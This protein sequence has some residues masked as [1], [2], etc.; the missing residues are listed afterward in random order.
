[1]ALQNASDN[2][3]VKEPIAEQTVLLYH[4]FS[5]AGLFEKTSIP[6]TLWTSKTGPIKQWYKFKNLP[7]KFLNLYHCLKRRK[8][9]VGQPKT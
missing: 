8:S 1:M 4:A 6:I 3:V 2:P 5:Q 7:L 9:Y